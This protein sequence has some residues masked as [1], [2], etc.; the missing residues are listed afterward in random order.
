MKTGISTQPRQRVY[1][2]V[3]EQ[4]LQGPYYSVTQSYQV[5]SSFNRA[6]VTAAA[7]LQGNRK[8]PLPWSYTITRHTPCRG[9]D[10][11]FTGKQPNGTWSNIEWSG[12]FAS[13]Q[14]NPS[15]GSPGFTS[16]YNQALSRL[17]EAVRGSLDLSVAVAEAG[18]TAR[19]LNAMERLNKL[20]IPRDYQKAVSALGR[21]PQR[22]LRQLGSFW[23]EFNLGWRPLIGDIYASADESLRIVLNRIQQFKAG[24]SVKLSR[25]VPLTLNYSVPGTGFAASLPATCTIRGKH[26]VRFK[27]LM[28]VPI[29]F[30][31]SRWT[32]L[33]PVSIAWELV[34]LSFV[35]DYIVDIGS[36]L[37]CMENGLLFNNRFKSGYYE[38]LRASSKVTHGSTAV[39]GNYG[40]FDIRRQT[41]SRDDVEYRRVLLTSYP[42]PRPPSFDVNL[43][44][45][46]LLTLASLLAQKLK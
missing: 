23:L 21:K 44:S 39:K 30:D 28:D 26:G 10:H 33:N 3:Q 8:T 32:S 36:W 22:I 15:D 46:R 6:S 9:V 41:L 20:P 7:I 42:F 2:F 31:I 38:E 27:V 14:P 1:R 43:G 45:S 35:V 4:P 25:D 24:A 19:M 5:S 13:D 12:E 11:R 37:R 40:G 16:L 17:G 34:P 18:S 29:G